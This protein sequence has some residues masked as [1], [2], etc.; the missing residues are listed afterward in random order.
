[1]DLIDENIHIFYFITDW[2]WDLDAIKLFLS[3]KINFTTLNYDVI[4]Q[5]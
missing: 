2:R 3:N 1:M 4:D 5:G